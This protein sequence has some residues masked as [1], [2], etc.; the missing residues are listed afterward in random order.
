MDCYHVLDGNLSFGYCIVGTKTV[1]YCSIRRQRKRLLSK[2][3]L[4]R[5][6]FVIVKELLKQ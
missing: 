4:I 6:V 2:N 3:N 5:Y 1:I